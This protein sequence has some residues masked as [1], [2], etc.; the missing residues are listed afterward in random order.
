MIWSKEETL[1]REEI[2]RIQ[3]ER[4][5]ETVSYIYEK[6]SPYRKKMDEAGVKPDD[7]QTLEDLQKMPF[8]YKAD[9]RDHY[10][11]GMFAVD[12]KR[13]CSFSCKFR[14]DRKT[15]GSWIYET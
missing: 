4:L 8:T 2:E 11:M 9:F 6:S 7:I 1:S 12:K 14:N 5:K 10:P 3:L 13:S 15:N